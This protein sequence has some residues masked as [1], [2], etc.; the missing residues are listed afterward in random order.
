MSIYSKKT[1]TT[2]EAESYFIKTNRYIESKDKTFYVLD[3]REVEK[4]IIL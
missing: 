2:K 4:E 3:I 1:L